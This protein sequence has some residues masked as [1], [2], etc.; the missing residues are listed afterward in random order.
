[1]YY[2]E[3]ILPALQLRLAANPAPAGPMIQIIRELTKEIYDKEDAETKAG[4]AAKV[5]EHVSRVEGE[6]G[7]EESERTPQQYQE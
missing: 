1:M 7:D 4:V 6:D 2:K 3:R 5:A